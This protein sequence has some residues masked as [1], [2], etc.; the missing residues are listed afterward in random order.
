MDEKDVF[1]R[2]CAERRDIPLFL[3]DA[4]W[5]AVA[6]DAWEVWVFDEADGQAFFL[7]LPGR[8]AFLRYV[9]PP[10]LTPFQGFYLL[11]GGTA[12]AEKCQHRLLERLRAMRLSL[13]EMNVA[14]GMVFSLFEG[15]G[16]RRTS[17]V[18]YRLYGLADPRS[19]W[20]GIA[21]KKK[22]EIRKGERLQ[23]ALSD[24][25][26]P[27]D[28]YVL[29]ERD[30]GR[31]WF[32]QEL[33][34]RLCDRFLPGQGELLAAVDPQ[35]RCLAAALLVW[36]D[37]TVYYLCCATPREHRR[38]GASAWLIW[39]ALQRYGGRGFSCFDFEGSMVKSIAFSYRRFGAVPASFDQWRRLTFLGHIARGVKRI[40]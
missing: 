27:D 4:W 23:L 16:Y 24:T 22:S 26:T 20:K 32:P 38:T 9:V 29:M 3:R 8:K 10:Q 31:V 40:F 2:W 17:R 18:T 15:A 1:R 25:L 39:Q 19:L 37:S 13:F 33:L 7:F 36:D 34:R 14:P 30:H 6:P 11:S 5:D 12:F 35:G 21:Y 28:F